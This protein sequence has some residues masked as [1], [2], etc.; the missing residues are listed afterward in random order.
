MTH[1]TSW[2]K[3]ERRIAKLFG[4]E[5]TP[6]SGESSRITSSDTLHSSL[7][8]EIKKRDD[9]LLK[10]PYRRDFRE[11]AENAE[12]E[13]KMAILI[14]SPKYAPDLKALVVM[15]LGDFLEVIKPEL[16][17]GGEER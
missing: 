10:Q 16:R 12:E 14:H 9:E 7:Y 13:G 5:R 3:A 2:K 17:R 15:R 8:I 11:V 4:A 6:L 1:K